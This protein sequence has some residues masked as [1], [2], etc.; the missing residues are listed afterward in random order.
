MTRMKVIKNEGGT[1]LDQNEEIKDGWKTY[2]EKLL[3]TDNP[4][5]DK[6]QPQPN[7]G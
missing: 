7:Q 3:N 1:A 4:R 6:E 5:Q 2:E